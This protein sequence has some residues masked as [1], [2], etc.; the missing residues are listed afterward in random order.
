[1][2]V[3][4]ARFFAISKIIA[5]LKGEIIKDDEILK[6]FIEEIKTLEPDNVVFNWECC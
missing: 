1:V 2:R 5:G 3:Y 4:T 6:E